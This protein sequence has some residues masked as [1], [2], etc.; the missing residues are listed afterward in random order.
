MLLVLVVVL[1]VIS[2]QIHIILFVSGCLIV[3]KGLALCV[4]SGC[5]ALIS[6]LKCW[7]EC[8]VNTT[9]QQDNT[10]TDVFITINLKKNHTSDSTKMLHQDS[11]R[12]IKLVADSLSS[13]PQ[14]F[15]TVA[16]NILIKTLLF[17]V[18]SLSAQRG[19]ILSHVPVPCRY[20]LSFLVPWQSWPPDTSRGYEPVTG[21]QLTVQLWSES[22]SFSSTC[23]ATR[24][25][26][27]DIPFCSVCR[28]TKLTHMQENLKLVL[29][30]TLKLVWQQQQKIHFEEYT[31]IVYL[32]T[33]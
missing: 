30:L 5:F 16:M 1:Q 18:F 13:A 31:H 24:V 8:S 9:I 26:T 33:L 27:P 25:W 12:R 7:S 6:R 19:V 14:G 3:I 32:L 20:Y 11:S 28:A 2:S 22:W 4:C 29:V 10:K 15:H 21:F 23:A 17:Q